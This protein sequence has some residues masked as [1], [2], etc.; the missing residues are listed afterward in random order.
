MWGLSRER[1]SHYCC[2]LGRASEAEWI[3]N[4]SQTATARA[5][6]PTE[7]PHQPLLL[8]HCSGAKVLEEEH[9]HKWSWISSVLNQG[10]LL[11][12]RRTWFW[13]HWGSDGHW[14]EG[15]P[16]LMP[17]SGLSPSSSHG[18]SCQH[19]WGRT[20]LVFTANPAL[21]PKSLGTCRLCRNAPT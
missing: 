6:T 21:S 12:Q 3:S 11:E 7:Y 16:C 15:K 13:P 8:Q 1:G 18:D 20:W 5:P 14:T 19:T 9:T 17:G 4:S 2:C 10:L